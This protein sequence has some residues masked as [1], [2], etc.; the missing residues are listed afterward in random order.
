MSQ[1]LENIEE[2]LRSH[3]L[4]LEDYKYSSIH[5]NLFNQN[6]K[7][8]S[9]H[10]IYKKL[11]FRQDERILKYQNIFYSKIDKNRVNFIR[12]SLE[13]QLITGTDT[14]IEN[15]EKV[16]GTSLKLKQRGRPKKDNQN[17]KVKKMYKKLVVLDK[18]N[19]KNLKI[20][21]LEDLKFAENS[22]FI[23]LVA[24]E[25]AL[26]AATFPV[27]FTADENPSIISL[28][29][30]SGDNLALNGDGKW[31]KKYVPS[32]LRRYPFSLGS[33]KEN[34]EQKVIL[35]DEES[36]LFSNTKGKQLFKKSGEQ[37]EVLEHAIKF[38]TSHEEQMVVTKNVAKII[39]E[40]G[41][42]EDKEIAVGEGEEKK[43]L[44]NGFKV[45]NREKLNA[46]SDDIL[47]DWVRKGIINVIEAHI[48][49]LENI[50]ILFDIAQQRQQ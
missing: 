32:F 42:L 1:P 8:I 22:S 25:V 40:S 41:I 50:Q 44:V 23:P 35:I 15:L 6:D 3:K 30:L 43:V 49:S 48:K 33:T 27:V 31:I 11:G 10:N 46:L 37:S 29:S 28:V 47:A 17:K 2:V 36:N 38:L 39:A 16:I 7:I 26:V 18:S 24:N 12:D 34:P 4:S 13:R 14:F 20:N 5:K 45:V 21:P 19:H 9:Y